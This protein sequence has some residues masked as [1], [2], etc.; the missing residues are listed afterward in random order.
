M[1]VIAD[2]ATGYKIIS[3]SNLGWF[4]YDPRTK[5][6]TDDLFIHYDDFSKE[7]VREW[8]HSMGKSLTDEKN[9]RETFFSYGFGKYLLE[10][11]IK[12]ISLKEKPILNN[13]QIPGS[14]TSQ[15]KNP[16]QWLVLVK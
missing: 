14:C 1:I 9:I 13:E 7:F 11:I 6:S 3:V 16:L 8:S 15:P 5:H 2:E 10:R 12:L 4:F